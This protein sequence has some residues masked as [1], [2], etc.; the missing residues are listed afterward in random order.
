MRSK[1]KSACATSYL[2][3]RSSLC[4]SN[5]LD[6]EVRTMIQN[7]TTSDHLSSDESSLTFD[8]AR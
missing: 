3:L 2:R 1:W 6:K 4:T 5:I 8:A 7:K